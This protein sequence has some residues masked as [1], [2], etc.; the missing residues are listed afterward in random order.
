MP[1]ILRTARKAYRCGYCDA[2]IQPGEK[3]VEIKRREPVYSGNQFDFWQTGIEYFTMRVHSK[4][5]LTCALAPE[6]G[7]L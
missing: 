1:A 6:I 4:Q 7:E 2:P 3:Y 5:S